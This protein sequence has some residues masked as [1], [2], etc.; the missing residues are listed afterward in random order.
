[1][2]A[3]FETCFMTQPAGRYTYSQSK[4]RCSWSIF[5]KSSPY[6]RICRPVYDANLT[7]RN[8]A[9]KVCKENRSSKWRCASISKSQSSSYTCCTM[10]ST[11]CQPSKVS[12]RS[13]IGVCPVLAHNEGDLVPHVLVVDG[14]RALEIHP[15]AG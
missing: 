5:R 9:T 15:A 6:K 7:T 10:Y 12:I 2:A 4:A 13:G 3:L 14:L 11:N 8:G 1:M